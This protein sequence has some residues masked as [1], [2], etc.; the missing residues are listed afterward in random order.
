MSP[1]DQNSQAN[2][3]PNTPE[4]PANVDNESKTHFGYKNDRK[5]R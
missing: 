2:D 1:T 5:R 3:L 4:T